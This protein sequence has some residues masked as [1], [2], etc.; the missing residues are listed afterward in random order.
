MIGNQRYFSH[1]HTLT[2]RV[3]HT[4]TFITKLTRKHAV[5]QISEGSQTRNPTRSVTWPDKLIE[6]LWFG[7]DWQL[8]RWNLTPWL[9]NL[10]GTLKTSTVML[11]IPTWSLRY[12][13]CPSHTR[14]STSIVSPRVC[15]GWYS[16]TRDNTINISTTSCRY[17]GSGI[18]FRAASTQSANFNSPG[19]ICPKGNQWLIK[20]KINIRKTNGDPF[21]YPVSITTASSIVFHFIKRWQKS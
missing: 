10:S 18:R 9:E 8:T 6:N 20:N 13:L 2:V 4:V 12:K 14:S 7:E 15:S 5:F 11:F 3:G 19:V 21:V 1:T 16:T 17:S